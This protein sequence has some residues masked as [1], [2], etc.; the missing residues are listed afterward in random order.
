MNELKKINSKIAAKQVGRL[1]GGSGCVIIGMV[2]FGKY[3]YQK[4]ITDTQFAISKEFP[5]E[6]EAIIDKLSKAFE[7]TFVEES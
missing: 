3:I 7:N 4:G 6:Y 1:I 5:D 2:L